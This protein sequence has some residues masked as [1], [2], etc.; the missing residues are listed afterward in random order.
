M[1]THVSGLN[2]SLVQHEGIL[3]FIQ[4]NQNDVYSRI[5]SLNSS[6]NQVLK[7]FKGLPDHSVIGEFDWG[8]VL[9]NML[10]VCLSLM[11]LPSWG[12]RILS[13]KQLT[14]TVIFGIT[15]ILNN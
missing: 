9:F 11:S 10:S 7:D 6:L 13:E 1:W 14:L 15:L 12:G 3:D 8:S 5:K 2:D 4:K